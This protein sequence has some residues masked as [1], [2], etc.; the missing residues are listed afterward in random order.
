[1]TIAEKQAA[2]IDEID[3]R[4]SVR[5][6][7]CSHLGLASIIAS[8]LC[9][10]DSP[11]SPGPPDKCSARC[12]AS[13]QQWQDK[14]P[15]DKVS[16][17]KSDFTEADPR[18]DGFFLACDQAAAETPAPDPGGPRIDCRASSSLPGGS[19]VCDVAQGGESQKRLWSVW[20]DADSQTLVMHDVVGSTRECPQGAESTTE[21]SCTLKG[22]GGRRLPVQCTG[23]VCRGQID[24]SDV[25]TND[26]D[27]VCAQGDCV[28]RK[29]AGVRAQFYPATLTSLS[30]TGATIAFDPSVPGAPQAPL[31]VTWPAPA[32]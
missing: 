11:D 14:C 7:P 31:E 1:M 21:A 3:G 15:A 23:G 6:V 26:T 4:Q 10:P 2:M 20:A 29:G 12:A 18:S 25:R 30:A 16:T 17:I 32:E 24:G 19:L 22:A 13:M 8:T 27:I 5:A 28:V 9:T